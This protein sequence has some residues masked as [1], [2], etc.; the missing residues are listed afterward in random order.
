MR[1]LP[2]NTMPT[3]QHQATDETHTTEPYSIPCYTP[4]PVPPMKD[5]TSDCVLRVAVWRDQDFMWQMSDRFWGH[6]M[7]K[8]I[9][10][11]SLQ[12]RVLTAIFEPAQ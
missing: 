3:Q 4:I 11:A 1:R 2:P 7:A 5:A 9:D 6:L 10:S 12:P 8:K